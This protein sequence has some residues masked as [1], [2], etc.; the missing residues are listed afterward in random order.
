[1]EQFIVKADRKMSNCT[2][3]KSDP[4]IELKNVE[5]FKDI[6][7]QLNFGIIKTIN[8]KKPNRESGSDK[9][10]FTL[11]DTYTDKEYTANIS[12]VSNGI[13]FRISAFSEYMDLLPSQFIVITMH[14]EASNCNIGIRAG[15]FYKYLLKKVQ[16]SKT[17]KK[18]KDQTENKYYIEEEECSKMTL[19][20]NV[21]EYLLQFGIVQSGR[22]VP[23]GKENFEYQMYEFEGCTKD[24]IGVPFNTILDVD[25]FDDF[26][27]VL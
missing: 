10:E 21:S 25:C 27:E 3:Y 15:G 4:Y 2:Q 8:N 7:P 12:K 1:M 6:W 20:S 9:F 19:S 17:A 23:K 26:E 11:I 5:N 14:K 22:T 18:T 16:K 24:Y 13:R